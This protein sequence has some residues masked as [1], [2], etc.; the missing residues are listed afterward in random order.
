[1]A[2]THWQTSA[3]SIVLGTLHRSSILLDEAYSRVNDWVSRC[4]TDGTC[5]RL[6]I[7]E[8]DHVCDGGREVF[9]AI[10]GYNNRT[11]GV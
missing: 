11:A 5:A 9:Q 7:V 6:N 2:Q 1:M 10:Q 3:A 8:V 4:I